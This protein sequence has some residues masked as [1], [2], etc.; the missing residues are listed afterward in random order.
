MVGLLLEKD[1][2]VAKAHLHERECPGK[3]V[4]DGVGYLQSQ[5]ECPRSIKV[6]LSVP[7]QVLVDD[8]VVQWPLSR[9]ETEIRF[10]V[11]IEIVVAIWEHF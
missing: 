7:H 2:L 1:V 9:L 11:E 4:V 5:V 8:R 3:F 10:D 6:E